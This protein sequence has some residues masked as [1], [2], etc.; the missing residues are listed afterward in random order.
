MSDLE[1]VLCQQC[2]RG[3]EY[4]LTH[5]SCN[6]QLGQFTTCRDFREHG[7]LMIDNEIPEPTTK[8]HLA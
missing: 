5:R 2:E 7:L 6:G 1:Y 4:I 3:V 8:M